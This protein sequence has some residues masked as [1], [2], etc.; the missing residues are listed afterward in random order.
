MKSKDT[1]LIV[2]MAGSSGSGKTTVLHALAKALPP[3]ALAVVSQDNYYLPR[4]MQQTDSQGVVN[5]DRPES[6]DR[7]SLLLDLQA[8]RS[9]QSIS[10]PEYTFNNPEA[11]VRQIV[12]K[13][14]PIIVVEGLFVFHFEEIDALLDKRVFILTDDQVSLKRRINRDTVERGYPEADVRYRWAHHV[15]P[16]YEQYLLPH[17]GRCGVVIHNNESYQADLARLAD[18]LKNHG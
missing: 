13:P 7:A 2:G 9:G 1:P 3:E 18:I 17:L 4:Q 5:F 6:I 10:H 12:I 8:L 14:A 11:A 15:R 16:A